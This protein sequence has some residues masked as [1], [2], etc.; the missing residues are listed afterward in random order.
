MAG[1]IATLRVM[2]SADD[3]ELRKGLGKS[4]KATKKW[5][6]AQK[7]RN[8]QVAKSFK[9]VGAAAVA[10]AGS[11]AVLTKSAVEYA[12]KI[13]KTASKLGL[14]VEELQKYRFAAERAGIETRT[15]DMSMQRFTRRLGEAQNG[16]GVLYKELTALGIAVRDTNGDLRSTEDVLYDYAE[17]IKEADGQAEKLRLAFVAF[18]SE[19][20]AMVNMFKD[21][22]ESL[23][24]LAEQMES[25]GLIMSEETTQKAAELSDKFGTMSQ[26]LETELYTA[27][28]NI[29]HDALPAIIASLNA[30]EFVFRGIQSSVYLLAASFEVW[31][32]GIY[33][34]G[35]VITD[36]FVGTARDIASG[37][38]KL[39]YQMSK[40]WAQTKLAAVEGIAGLVSAADTAMSKAPA[41]LKGLTGYRDGSYTKSNNLLADSIRAEIAGADAAIQ[42]VASA[43]DSEVPTALEMVLWGSAAQAK[44]SADELY[45]KAVEAANRAQGALTGNG[46]AS[47]GA[48]V[49]DTVTGTGPNAPG[50]G[51]ESPE[52]VAARS[53]SEEIIAVEAETQDRIRAMR[54]STAMQSVAILGGWVDANSKAGAVILGIQE[55][56]SIANVVM[57]G[58]EAASAAWKDGNPLK[59]ALVIASSA[60][61]VATSINTIKSASGDVKGQFHDGI[62]NV[63]S[64]GTYLLEQGERVVDK[65]LN[66]DLKQAL[67]GGNGSMAGAGGT[68]AL[69]ITVNGVT[70]AETINR[71][72]NEQRPQFE[73]MLRDINYDRAGQGLL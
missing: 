57:S 9:A 18:D 49:V 51:G 29:A 55:G 15:L 42:A 20:A 35:A 38:A 50:V 71:V 64:T 8:E 44:A 7:R 4:D 26:I 47:K 31:R 67:D 72:I 12:D 52:V 25:V 46:I 13:G 41:W 17:A 60:A 73:Q 56:M 32:N 24:E 69:S 65:R 1:P 40:M 11:F 39:P 59:A 58:A 14:T 5:A 48:A 66:A 33:K 30:A 28:I 68:N 22:S 6:A 34:L 53:V 36:V 70:D 2:L 27:A 10:A 3:A 21:G 37:L 19:G 63:P 23:R 45:N 43:R 62:D 16:T 61:Q 54:D